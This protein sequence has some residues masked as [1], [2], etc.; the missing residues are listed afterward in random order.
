M[1]LIAILSDRWHDPCCFKKII[2]SGTSN[3]LYTMRYPCF[4]NL[5]ER[6]GP[7]LDTLLIAAVATVGALTMRNII[8]ISHSVAYGCFATTAVLT[9]ALAIAL[10][11]RSANR[12]DQELFGDD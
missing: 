2:Y 4:F 5:I 3:E 8:P 10:R 7:L 12:A 6:V 1:L 11:M 9:I